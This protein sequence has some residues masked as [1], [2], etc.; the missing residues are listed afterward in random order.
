VLKE[1]NV[2]GEINEIPIREYI[3]ERFDQWMEEDEFIDKLEKGEISAITPFGLALISMETFGVSVI[4]LAPFPLNFY[5]FYLDLNIY[6]DDGLIIGEIF[7]EKPEDFV[8]FD[9]G[10]DSRLLFFAVDSTTLLA[11][12]GQIYNVYEYITNNLDHKDWIMIFTTLPS[13]FMKSGKKYLSKIEEDVY[14]LGSGTSI[15]LRF[16]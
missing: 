2:V 12:K 13:S 14:F 3:K 4:G 8:K 1:G 15:L 6:Y 5:P 16:K 9:F 7:S 10:D 11:Y